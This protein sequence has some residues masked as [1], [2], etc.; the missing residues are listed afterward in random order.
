MNTETAY[1]APVVGPVAKSNDKDVPS[2]Y[3]N[4]RI[5]FIAAILFQ[6]SCLAALAIPNIYTL[7][8]GTE[9]ELMSRPVDPYSLFKG[10]YVTLT[11]D[12]SR[13][14]VP[15]PSGTDV[16]V[17]LEKHGD[18][19]V[20]KDISTTGKPKVA[21]KQIAMRGKSQEYGSVRFGI[22]QFY[23]PEKSGH[24]MERSPLHVKVAVDQFGHAVVKRIFK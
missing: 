17:L 10:D 2:A 19:Y 20:M 13:P 1:E 15:I 23:V 16:W 18:L 9:I 7:A 12:F 3:K 21:A 22:E 5:Y 24:D 6:F 4:N 14:K 8:T 11:Y